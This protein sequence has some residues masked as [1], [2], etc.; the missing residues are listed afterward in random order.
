MKS[1]NQEDPRSH[2]LWM[3]ERFF[4]KPGPYMIA[5]LSANNILHFKWRSGRLPGWRQLLLSPTGLWIVQGR[6]G[7]VSYQ[8]TFRTVQLRL[9]GMNSW[10]FFGFKKLEVLPSPHLSQFGCSAWLYCTPR[11][12]KAP[13]RKQVEISTGITNSFQIDFYWNYMKL[14]VREMSVNDITSHVK[15]RN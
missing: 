11:P 9:W 3:F 13:K 2:F 12:E 14:H 8:S 6:S 15:I 10:H 4:P 5:L 7:R 1:I